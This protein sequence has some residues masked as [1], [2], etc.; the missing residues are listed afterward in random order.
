MNLNNGPSST[1][2]ALILETMRGVYNFISVGR[3][4]QKLG[5]IIY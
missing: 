3:R 2:S 4:E 5:V 1:T